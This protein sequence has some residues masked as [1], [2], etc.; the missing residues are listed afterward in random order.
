MEL[1]E[2]LAFLKKIDLFSSFSEEDLA[3][4]AA[5][6]DEVSLADGAL[7][8]RQGEPGLDMFIL[9]SGRLKVSRDSRTI[10]TIEPSNY[11]GEM[12]IIEQKTRSA[13]VYALAPSLLLRITLELFHEFFSRQPPALVAMMTTLSQRIRRDTEDIA[14]ECEKANMMIHDMKNLLSPFYLLEVLVKKV[15]E[16]A[17]HRYVEYMTLA[18]D[19]LL[20]MMDEALASAKRMEWPSRKVPHSLPDLVRGVVASEFAAH[21]DLAG[22]ELRVRVL[23]DVP[24]FAFSSL[25]IRRVLNNLIVNAAQASGP[26]S[27]IE[28]E[29]GRSDGRAVV[30][31]KDQGK[32]I[33]DH[34]KDNIFQSHFTTKAQ[35]NGLG[36]ASCKFI[37]EKGHGGELSFESQPG[38]GT[39]F[40]FTL[41]L[42]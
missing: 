21:P 3:E 38:Q 33:P 40:V 16:V 1:A 32:G 31:V 22:K 5:K 25:D 37:I 4:F 36:L 24:E 28:V 10:T 13:S 17:G 8:F 7:L 27:A 23:D 34:Q 26:G 18:R 15:P 14:A 39:T 29:V 35:G 19:N 30:R 12:A 2:R 6:V 41:P 9:V 20:L 42:A 11:V